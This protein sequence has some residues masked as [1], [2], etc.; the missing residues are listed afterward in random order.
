MMCLTKNWTTNT[1]WSWVSISKNFNH[2]FPTSQPLW[3]QSWWVYT[4]NNFNKIFHDCWVNEY[5]QWYNSAWAICGNI[6]T[7]VCWTADNVNTRNFPTS[8][9]CTSGT[10]VNIDTLW[11]DLKYN[12]RC[13]W[14][15]W[16]DELCSAKR[17]IDW[18]RSNWWSCSA[19]CWW[20]TQYR[21]CNNPTPANW[22]NDCSWGSSQACNTQACC[23]NSSFT[24]TSTSDS[25]WTCTSYCSS[26]GKV[27]TST[28]HSNEGVNGMKWGPWDYWCSTNR[29]NSCGA[30]SS[31]PGGNGCGPKYEK[32]NKV[33]ITCNCG[34]P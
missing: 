8:W 2:T 4:S 17:I 22:W 24:F 28:S 32:C 7:W 3:E 18:W 23:S 29:L 1:P 9:L 16:N 14:D 27:C 34:C 30:N 13:N 19:S 25:S 21:T 15:L 5:L 20:W 12:W 26:L 6:I 33:T 11:S 31:S 10:K